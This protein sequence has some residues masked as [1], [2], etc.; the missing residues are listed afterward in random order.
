MARDELAVIGAT[1][2][3]LYREHLRSAGPLARRVQVIEVGEPSRDETLQILRGIRTQYQDFHGVHI[4]DGALQT[5]IRL[6][7]RVGRRRPDAAIELVDDAA[8]AVA[9]S[10][11]AGQEMATV[12]EADV[13]AV[14]RQRTDIAGRF[15]ARRL[16]S[17][18]SRW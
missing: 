1:T 10:V 3:D 15:S 8:A 9:L 7:G 13:V 2:P 12:A 4:T 17:R 18:R 14:F 16:A 5:A 6:S 11:V